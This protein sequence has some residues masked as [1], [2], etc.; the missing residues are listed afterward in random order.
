M[1]D[2]AAAQWAICAFPAIGALMA[3]WL[4]CLLRERGIRPLRALARLMRRPAGEALAVL[5]CVGGLV[6]HGATKHAAS[7]PSGP[8]A[9]MAVSDT[10]LAAQAEADSGPSPGWTNAACMVCATGIFPGETSV[11]IRAHW[12]SPPAD[13][14]SGIEVY[15]RPRLDAGGWSEVGTAAIPAGADG[16]AIEIPRSILPPGGA[17]AMFFTLGLDSDTDGDGLSDAFERLVSATDPLLADTDGDGLPDGWEVRHGFNP[18]SAPGMGEADS[19]ADGDGLPNAAEFALGTDPLNADTDGDG[20]SDCEEAGCVVVADG[21]EWHDSAGLPETCARPPDGGLHSHFGASAIAQLADGAAVL[22]D[23]MARAVCFDNGV[24]Y[25][26]SP[27][28]P[29]PFVFPERP[30]PLNR[31]DYSMGDILVAPYWCASGLVA[32]DASSNMRTGVVAGDGCFVAECRDVGLRGASGGRMTYQ[33]I[34]PGGTGNVVRVSYLSSD[35]G[36]GGSGAVAGVQVRRIAK[37]DGLYSLSWDFAERGPIP[38]GTT[39]EY[40]LGHG[41]DPLRADTDGDG[42][43]DG[44][45]AALHRTDPLRVDSDGDGLSDMR[46]LALGTDPMSPDT[47]GDGLLDGWEAAHGLDPLVPSGDDGADADIDGDGL[48][49]IQ[50][51]RR[52]TDPWNP[53]TDGDGLSDGQEVNVHGTSP[54]VADT[55]GD[56]LNDG[57]EVNVYGTS[58]T[59]TDTD[60]DGLPDGWEIDNGLD[61]Q[62]P[63]GDDGASGDADGDGLCNSDE[64]ALGTDPRASDTDG[65]GVS[66]FQEICNGSDPTDGTDGGRPSAKS[67]NRGMLLGIGGDYAAWSMTVAGLGQADGRQDEFSMASPGNAVRR[68]MILKKGRS[69]RLT[70]RWLNS[71]GHTDPNWYCWQATVN[72][73]PTG[74]SYESY[75]ATR[76]PG[77][78]VVCGLGWMAENA[79]GLLTSHVHMCDGRGGNVAEGLEATLHV[80]RCEVTVCDPDN[81]HWP[82]LEASRVLLDDDRLR[83]RVSVMPAIEDFDLF[84]RV[85]GSNIVVAT[86]GTCPAGVGIPIDA[87][88]FLCSDTNSEIRM[89]RTHAQLAELGLLPPQDEDGVDEMAWIDMGA[90]D[91]GLPSNLTDGEAFS[92]IGYAFRGKATREASKTLDST[93]PNSQPS[94]SFFKAAGCEIVTVEYGGVRSSRRQIKNQAD[95]FYYS[96]HGDL[97]TGALQGGFLPDLVAPYWQK[98]LNCAV[99]AG[100]SVLNIGKFR[101]ES[102]GW[103]TSL[104]WHWRTKGAVPSPGKIWAEKIR[105]VLLGFCWRAPL[106]NAGGLEIAEKFASE[107]NQG[108]DWITAWRNATNRKSGYNACAIDCT[109]IPNRYWYW[110]E[111]NGVSSWTNV[112]KGATSQW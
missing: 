2:L 101:N 69:Y 21:F 12:P 17:E 92:S 109:V 104:Y 43:P 5:A 71:D 46:E 19:D 9:A 29:D 31:A 50:E 8:D 64:L 55:D 11:L 70:M 73:L 22:G 38:P 89:T 87:S 81:A 111:S 82:E 24:V 98:E 53:D 79:D 42:L 108:H 33:V 23:A 16:V 47:D 83:I 76:L 84:R 61:P 74:P 77:N 95:I 103:T 51:Q 99:F 100:C 106:D 13:G 72:G 93:P 37:E 62:S 36:F 112:L 54:T 6:H 67:P 14:A 78:E 39:V 80:Y 85:M 90:V 59:N 48:A 56:G 97:R 28:P 26:V 66:D 110:V 105:G 65:D 44:D 20:L 25:L 102:F 10:S 30:T 88:E 27:G 34:V 1:R 107:V 4:A 40:R 96:G 52:G 15:A 60:G 68:P 58:P 86:S 91:S 63:A 75:K 49:N 41:T 32:G 3:V 7:S 18:L 35:D 94:D 57:E 45:E